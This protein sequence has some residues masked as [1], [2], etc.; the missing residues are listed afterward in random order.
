M[1]APSPAASPDAPVVDKSISRFTA[2]DYSYVKR[3]LTRI[4]IIASAIFIL[5]IVLAFVL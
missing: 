4:A 1:P 3:E 2:R 5:I